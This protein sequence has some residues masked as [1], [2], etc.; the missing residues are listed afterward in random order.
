MNTEPEPLLA[1]FRTIVTSGDLMLTHKDRCDRCGA[2]AYVHAIIDSN[3]CD[4]YFCG[5]HWREASAKITPYCMYI[6][7]ER[8]ALDEAVKDDHWVE[9]KPESLPPRKTI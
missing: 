3:Q 4:L 8:R 5:H 6:N 1:Y 9:G 2:R 7:D